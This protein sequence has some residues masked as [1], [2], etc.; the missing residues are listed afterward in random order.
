MIPAANTIHF[1]ND[2]TPEQRQKRKEAQEVATGV[3]AAGVTAGVGASRFSARKGSMGMLRNMYE[4]MIKTSKAASRNSEVATGLWAKFVR[5]SRKFANHAWGK[6]SKFAD[7]K[8][9]APIIKS[10]I[11]KKATAVF[12]GVTAG[13]VLISG[14]GKATRDGRVAIEDIKDRLNIAA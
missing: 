11:T 9:L 7:N 5:D 13:F 3:G 10:P 14:L 1:H 2:L 4:N 12:G 6:I 8:Y